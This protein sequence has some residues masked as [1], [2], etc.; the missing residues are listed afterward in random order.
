MI[1]QQGRDI[2]DGVVLH[3]ANFELFLIDSLTRY[4]GRVDG[5]LQGS[6]QSLSVHLGVANLR[7]RARANLP[8]G[9]GPIQGVVITVE[10]GFRGGGTVQY[11]T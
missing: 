3:M 8:K 6:I 11:S 2:Y 9:Q 4:R 1:P 5:N 10:W 7:P